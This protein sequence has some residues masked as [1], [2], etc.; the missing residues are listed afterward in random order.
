MNPRVVFRKS[1]YKIL[2]AMRKKH[3][4]RHQQN[5]IRK[6]LPVPARRTN[7]CA[8]GRGA[9][10]FPGFRFANPEAN[11]KGQ[12]CRRTANPEHGA[13]SPERLHKVRRQCRQ[14]ITHRISALQNSGKNSP[15]LL[16]SAFQSQRSAHAPFSAHTDSINRPQDQEHGVARREPAQQLDERKEHYIR[17]QWLASPIAVRKQAEHQRSHGPHHQGGE[18][19]SHNLA[20][21]HVELSGQ[22]IH[23]EHQHKEIEGVQRPAEVA[24]G[25]R[26]PL[27]GSGK[28]GR[29]AVVV[30]IHLIRAFRACPPAA[31]FILKELCERERTCHQ[32]TT[33]RRMQSGA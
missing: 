7:N 30:G 1:G 2:G 21:A 33:G 22:R 3:H 15:P 8:H 19:R 27:V 11:I 29:R 25:Y 16:G 9:L 26:V 10:L 17:H 32:S 12:Q 23:Q 28:R 20:L 4:E 31:S 14:Q 6:Y 5:E 18:D 24:G 13:P